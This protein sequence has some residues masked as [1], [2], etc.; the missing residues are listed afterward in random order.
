MGDFGYLSIVI[1]SLGYPQLVSIMSLASKVIETSTF[2]DH[3]HLNAMGV[4]FDLVK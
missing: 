2:Q 1:V 4:K 3:S